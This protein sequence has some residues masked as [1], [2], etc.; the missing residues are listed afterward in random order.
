MG[1]NQSTDGD[2]SGSKRE[3][4]PSV[5]ERPQ[6][7][8]RPPRSSVPIG[9]ALSSERA[10]PRQDDIL[11]GKSHTERR[12]AENEQYEQYF[13]DLIERTA[14]DLI[15]VSQNTAPLEGRDAEDRAHEYKERLTSTPLSHAAVASIFGIPKASD[16]NP[17]TQ[18]LLDAVPISSSDLQFMEK[19]AQTVATAFHDMEVRSCGDIVVKFPELADM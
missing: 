9:G 2:V 15:D 8:D 11:L 5:A 16:S 18:A 13:K 19:S 3:R 12:E 14:N 7:I 1:C 6:D 17:S 4:K 10:G